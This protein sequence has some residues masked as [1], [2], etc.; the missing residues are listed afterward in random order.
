MKLA[1]HLLGILLITGCLPV[2]QAQIYRCVDPSGHSTYSN[3]K[4]GVGNKK[5]TVVSREVSVVPASGSG[6][7]PAP[8]GAAAKPPAAQPASAS[9]IDPSLQRNRDNDRRRILEEEMQNA[10]RQLVAA[11][12]GLAQ[13]EATRSG[14]EKNYQKV[15]E[16]LKPYQNEVRI[17]EENV[18]ALRR[19]ISTLR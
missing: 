18:A 17:N 4:E 1:H 14:D 5:C 15:L 10:E 16:R 3:D 9:R 19:E 7:A 2:A 8:A 12:Q 11:K 13:Q 6:A